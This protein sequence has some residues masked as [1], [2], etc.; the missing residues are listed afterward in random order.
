MHGKKWLL[1][2]VV[3]FFIFPMVF[4]FAGWLLWIP[5][6]WWLSTMLRHGG[7]WGHGWDNGE[8]QRYKQEWRAQAKAWKHEWKHDWHD[9]GYW[10][11]W[12]NEKPK[13]D[14]KPKRRGVV[15]TDGEY[16]EVVDSPREA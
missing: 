6:I 16:L 4:K 9:R 3:F 15:T 14:E 7:G 2:F 11:D 5:L 10:N 8:W 1:A 13:N 12:N